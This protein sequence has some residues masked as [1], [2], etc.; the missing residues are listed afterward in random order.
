MSFVLP[1]FLITVV[2]KFGKLQPGSDKKFLSLGVSF[3]FQDI[4]HERLKDRFRFYS[5]GMYKCDVP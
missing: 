1:A 3:C 2:M 4:V 5:M